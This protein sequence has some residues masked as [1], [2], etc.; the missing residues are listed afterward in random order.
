MILFTTNW[1]LVARGFQQRF[2]RVLWGGCVAVAAD[3]YLQESSFEVKMLWN[4]P[5][6]SN[7]HMCKLIQPHP[8]LPCHRQTHNS[9]HRPSRCCA[10]SQSI[11]PLKITD[12]EAGRRPRSNRAISFLFPHRAMLM[13]THTYDS[14][15]YCFAN[16]VGGICIV[17][18]LTF[19][20]RYRRHPERLGRCGVLVW[21]SR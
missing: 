20:W 2:V 14:C 11:L 7:S 13:C 6:P 10:T 21:S 8:Y 18:V 3:Q 5:P 16:E 15:L 9:S 1:F 19:L 12:P 4:P 17:V